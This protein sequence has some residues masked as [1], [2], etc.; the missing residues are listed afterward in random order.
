MDT[1]ILSRIS[2]ID[3]RLLKLKALYE[4]EGDKESD[5]ISVKVG[6]IRKSVIKLHSNE[7]ARQRKKRDDDA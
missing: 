5:A 3:N 6:A 1:R 2:D 7:K 4:L